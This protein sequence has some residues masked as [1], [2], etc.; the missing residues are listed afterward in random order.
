M[1]R[2]THTDLLK[3][4][5]EAPIPLHAH[6]PA[7]PFPQCRSLRLDPDVLF[8]QDEAGGLELGLQEQRVRRYKRR[9]GVWA[10]PTE[11]PLHVSLEPLWKPGSEDM[12]EVGDH[13]ISERLFSLEEGDAGISTTKI[14]SQKVYAS[15]CLL[16]FGSYR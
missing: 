13:G 11:D 6:R 2:C 15:S 14:E 5:G 10:P 1:N 9:D 8:L 7:T 12:L 16:F 4:D 3:N